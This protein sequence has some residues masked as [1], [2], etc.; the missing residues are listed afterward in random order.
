MSTASFLQDAV[1]HLS[2]L[3][4]VDRAAIFVLEGDILRGG[5]QVGLSEEY[6]AAI[7]GRRIGP[8]VAIIGATCFYGTAQVCSDV[9]DDPRWD[10][11]R[12]FPARAGFRSVWCVPLRLDD[13]TVLGGFAVYHEDVHEP[14]ADELEV[15]GSYAS[16]VALGLD[17]LRSQA[18]VAAS[19]EAV[20]VALSSALDAR[21]EYTGQHSSET[22]ELVASVAERL[23]LPETEVARVRQVAVLHD[24]GKL[25]VPT[26]IL[27]KPDPLTDEEWA[28]M[29]E[30]PA[31]G[32]RILSGIPGLEDIATA[33]RHEHERWDGGGYPDGLAGD[34][35]P[36]AS[37]IVFACDAWHAMTSDRPYRPAMAL[38]AALDQLREHAGTQFDPRVAQALLEVLGH[39]ELSELEVFSPR[40]CAE[41]AQTEA[42]EELAAELGATDIFVFN[43][44][45][46]D[47]YSHLGGVGRGAGWAGNIEI[48]SAEESLV[49]AALLDQRPVV[50]AH[51]TTTRIVGPYYGG[52]AVL[53]PCDD[54]WIVVFGAPDRALAGADVDL[55]ARLA[56]RVRALVIDVS[57]A[58]RL[59]DELEVLAAVRAITMV[60]ADTVEATL[61][62]VADRA[63]AALSCEYGAVLTVPGD[64]VDSM[65]GWSDRGWRPAD[66]DVARRALASYATAPTA[67]PLLCQDTAGAGGDV[68]E[69]FGRENA[70]SSIH[71]LPIGSPA[72][73]MLLVVHAEPGLRG[74]TALCQRVASAM[75]DAAEVVLRR[76]IAQERLTSEN[77]KLAER[78]RTDVV[79]GVSSRAAWEETIRSEEL[80]RARSD[81]P[82][83]IVVLDLDELKAVNDAEGHAAG[84]ALLRRAGTLLSENV[85]ATDFVARIG[86]DEFGVLLRYSDETDAATWCERL[87][88]SLD[89]AGA[90]GEDV[91]SCSL[92]YASVPPSSTLAEALA[93][94][95]RRM[96]AAKAAKRR[97]R[98]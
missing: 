87:R 56:Q 6:L 57:P 92:G 20:V 5:A 97:T 73:A 77:A 26:E 58:K 89:A 41:A 32:E 45:S 10:G 76:A 1:C 63:A 65:L 21:D 80:H 59:A 91:P 69:G 30:H 84:D 18:S 49:R 16:V 4:S 9:N 53:V 50:V 74:F 90:R 24:I 66:P 34:L 7:D 81:R 44:V 86:G 78:L 61:S 29:R 31:I 75:S 85:R 36:L 93:E 13:G 23:G 94:A 62:A 70:A 83:S 95:D 14:S 64:D 25:G 28:L 52:S 46:A 37:R 68:P 38:D 96:Y 47:V 60:S 2:R 79:T 40:T 15:A 51:D 42:L 43:K 35:I 33:I 27:T 71:V 55:A 3:C 54:E 39:S 98:G 17:R 22:A 82:A 8:N 48:R 67:L 72:V 19:Y 88:A 11:F 12:E